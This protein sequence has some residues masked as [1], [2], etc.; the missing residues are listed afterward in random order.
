MSLVKI[1]L[2]L[3]LMRFGTELDHRVGKERAWVPGRWGASPWDPDS[4]LWVVFLPPTAN[5]P[6]SWELDS[7]ITTWTGIVFC[8]LNSGN[9]QLPVPEKKLCLEI[10]SILCFPP[11]PFF[12]C[13]VLFKLSA[14]DGDSWPAQYEV[15]YQR[16]NRLLTSQCKYL[17][18]IKNKTV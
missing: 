7:W 3:S 2:L 12:H 8:T 18:N 1:T 6:F 13:A 16:H 4:F 9:D 15:F 11:G 5:I 14:T 10:L 17:Y